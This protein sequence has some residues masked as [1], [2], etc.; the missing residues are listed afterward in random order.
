MV[1]QGAGKVEAILTV[2]DRGGFLV[3]DLAG[4]EQ[5]NCEPFWVIDVSE[6]FFSLENVL[7]LY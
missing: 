5:I 6:N 3:D 1:G 7:L 2:E 4:A